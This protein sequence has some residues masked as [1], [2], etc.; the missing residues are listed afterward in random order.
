[1]QVVSTKYDQD[2]I[3]DYNKKVYN[4]AVRRH[5]EKQK[6]FVEHV[7]NIRKAKMRENHAKKEGKILGW[8]KFS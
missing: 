7:N 1:M 8:L 6:K 4:R 5:H 2:R 3:R